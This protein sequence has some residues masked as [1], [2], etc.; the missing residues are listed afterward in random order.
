[1]P[2]KCMT[3]LVLELVRGAYDPTPLLG[4]ACRTYDYAQ[5]RVCQAYDPA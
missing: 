1:M 4:R 3:P 5:P 2:E